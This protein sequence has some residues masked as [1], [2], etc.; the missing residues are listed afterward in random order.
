MTKYY[1]SYKAIFDRVKTDLQAVSSI[2]NVV[3]GEQFRVTDVPMAIVNPEHTEIKQGAFGS[4]LE[5]KIN[6][7]VIV[8][9]RE[10][11]P[12]NWFTDVLAPM[13]D[14]MDAVLADR[15][16]GGTVKDTTPTLFSPGEIKAQGKLWYGGVLR[17]QCL[18]H[19]SP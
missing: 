19:F 4:L 9:I 18:L 6:F 13:G 8:M 11:E 5:N 2:K 1:D 10:T 16:L 7:V 12:T 3:L 15:S 17:F 14:V